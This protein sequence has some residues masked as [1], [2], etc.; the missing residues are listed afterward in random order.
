MKVKFKSLLCGFLA[1][2]ILISLFPLSA[3]A[4]SEVTSIA[5]TLTKPKAGEV[6]SYTATLPD[7]ASTEV[8]SVKWS[9]ADEIFIE[10]KTYTVTIEVGIKKGFDEVFAQSDKI[11]ATMNGYKIHRVKNNGANV[12]VK[13]GW[14]ISSDKPV[15]APAASGTNTEVKTVSTKSG[16]SD[17]NDGAYYAKAVKWAVDKKITSGTSA[18]TFSPDDTCTRAQILTFLWRAVGSPKYNSSAPFGDVISDDYFFDASGWAK[19]MDMVSGGSF[20]PDTPCTRAFTVIYLWKNAGSPKTEPSS[21][22]SD[23]SAAA[24]YA[25]AVAWAVNS[26][27]TSGTSETTFSPNDTCTRGQIV[28][29]LNRALSA[30]DAEKDDNTIKTPENNNQENKT[31]VPTIN[32]TEK[33][34]TTETDKTDET[35]KDNT[36]TSKNNENTK[37]DETKKDN[38]TKNDNAKKDGLSMESIKQNTQNKAKYDTAKYETAVKKALR[39]ALG[40]NLGSGMTQLQKALLLHD[41]L[42][43]N[44]QYDETVSKEY[45]HSEYGAIVN[46]L[47]VCD[48]YTRAYND[49]LSR[50]G[51][52]AEYVYG[53][54]G[55]ASM[56]TAHAWSR[57]TIDGKKYHVDVTF[58]DPTPDVKGRTTH[59]CFLVSD[60]KLKNHIGYDLHCTDTK[61]DDNQILHKYYASLV[62]DERINKFYYVDGTA[63]KTT[64]DFSEPMTSSSTKDGVNPTAALMTDDGKFF[65]FFKPNNSTSEYPMYLYCIET[66]EYYRYTVKG[67][68]N[69]IFDRLVQNGNNIEPTRDYY[70]GGLYYMSKADASIPIPKNTQKRSVVFDPNYSGGK[71]TSFEYLDNYWTNGDGSLDALVRKGYTFGGWHTAK[72]GGEKIESLDSLKGDNVTLCAHWWGSWTITKE[73]TMTESGRAVREL[74]G[75]TSVKDEI[76]IPKLSDTSVWN[77]TKSISATT[78]RDGFERYTSEY[79]EVTV[80]LPKLEEK[81]EYGIK[82]KN[83][84]V[85]ITVT[86]ENTYIVGFEAKE[87]G[88]VVSTGSMKTITNGAGEYRVIYPKSFTPSGSVTAT[89]YDRDMKS[90][91]STEYEVK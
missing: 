88:E 25:Q 65:L 14:K 66:G 26:G 13:F 21:K 73:P 67:V 1:A 29:F 47:A 3:F 60:A 11:A 81:F 75:Y 79:G 44:C 16:F 46:G 45:V 39:E 15:T 85:Y 86:D 91:C 9:P 35:A 34:E 63:V 49:L 5:L 7:G 8:V 61:Y 62:W 50:V 32:P 23:V 59:T 24:D 30:S 53:Y 36:D 68:K 70:K 64:S 41:W 18:T 89:L 80:V 37:T 52:E 87:N 10:D 56:E 28:T 4:S 90:I 17:V 38:T 43:L 33:G 2:C 42:L 57:V 19:G 77:K 54:V 31:D 6:P 40:D 78:S 58:D 51:I 55:K 12:T 48:G 69:I 84:S 82:Y 22:F 72:D 27:V 76:T 83:G 71:M 74:D 20:E